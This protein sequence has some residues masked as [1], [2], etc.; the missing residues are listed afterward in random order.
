MIHAQA[1]TKTLA[2]KVVHHIYFGSRRGL[3][4]CS[5]IQLLTRPNIAW[6]QWSVEKWRFRFSMFCSYVRMYGRT[7]TI[8]R[9]NEPLFKLMLWL[10]LGR[11]SKI[12]D[13]DIGC[14]RTYLNCLH[15]LPSSIDLGGILYLHALKRYACKLRAIISDKWYYDH[16]YPSNPMNWYLSIHRIVKCCVILS[17]TY[18]HIL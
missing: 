4:W 5:P 15:L 2:W 11:G 16:W 7:D 13:I 3:N 18:K 1:P 9:N 17:E 12:E 14:F 10:V 8:N 6:L